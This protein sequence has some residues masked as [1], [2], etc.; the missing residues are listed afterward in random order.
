MSWPRVTLP[1][2]VLCLALVLVVAGI[3]LHG[4]RPAA[5]KRGWQNLLARPNGRL[6]L[7]F[8]L[9]PLMATILAV[10]D[11]VKDART[12]RSPYF[13]T[14]IADPARRAAHLHEGI[15]ATGKIFVIAIAI[16]IAYQILELNEFYPGEAVVVA[17]LLAFVPYLALRG[18]A[19][20]LARRLRA[21]TPARSK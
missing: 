10:R 15:A 18:P 1:R 7:R 2:L 8:I 11:G 21:G 16:D 12:G 6:A 3:V 14:V 17:T 5:F 13:R 19:A 4:I 20:R 9:Q